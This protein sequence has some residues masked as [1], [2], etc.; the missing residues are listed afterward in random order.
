MESEIALRRKIEETNSLL[1]ATIEST[2]DGILVVDKEGKVSFYNQKFLDMWQI[3]DYILFTSDDETLLN[4]VLDQLCSPGEFM[5]KV[6]ELYN[7]PEA[8][9][10][11]SLAF[12]DGR[13]YERYSQPHKIDD[14]F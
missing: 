3:P 9:S 14:N 11:D 13:V 6:V 12:K 1:R 5:Q 10:L 4:Y 8:I 2:A 7:R